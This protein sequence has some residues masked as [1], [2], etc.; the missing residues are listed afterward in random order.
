MA[1][2]LYDV[3]K[4]CPPYSQ[5]G[6]IQLDDTHAAKMLKAKVVQPHAPKPKKVEPKVEPKVDPAK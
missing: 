4:D 2:K 6:L 1:L 5:G 3:I